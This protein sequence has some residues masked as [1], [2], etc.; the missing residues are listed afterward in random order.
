MAFDSGVSANPSDF[1]KDAKSA[2][3]ARI[4]SAVES[5]VEDCGKARADR[6]SRGRT[7]AGPKTYFNIGLNFFPSFLVRS[8][9]SS[10]KKYSPSTSS[11]CASATDTRYFDTD[12]GPPGTNTGMMRTGMG[13][14]TDLL[15]VPRLSG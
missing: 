7:S 8:S 15:D 14:A 1:W 2:S 11:P 5:C 12:D 6:N 3:P 13:A 9:L 10:T 4:S